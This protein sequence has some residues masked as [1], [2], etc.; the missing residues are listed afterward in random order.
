MQINT[1]GGCHLDNNLV[2][3]ALGALD[4]S[5]IDI[6]FIETWGILSALWSS[7][8]ARMPRS[9]SSASPKATISPKSTRFSSTVPVP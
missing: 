7:I 4:L 3:E 5:E 1:E 6:L 8:V 2:M 9:P